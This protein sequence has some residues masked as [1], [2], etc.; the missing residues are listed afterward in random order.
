MKIIKVYF[1]VSIFLLAGILLGGCA[2]KPAVDSD[3]DKLIKEYCSAIGED[4]EKYFRE[5]SRDASGVTPENVCFSLEENTSDEVLSS[6]PVGW[7]EM[8]R[9]GEPVMITGL[10]KKAEAAKSDDYYTEEEIRAILTETA[11]RNFTVDMYFDNPHLIY[12]IRESGITVSE[13]KAADGG[14]Y[15]NEYDYELK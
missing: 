10:F 3:R 13:I 12:K 2:N 11:D 1:C 8:I 9:N 7:E 6:E 4:A 15:R 5:L 14:A